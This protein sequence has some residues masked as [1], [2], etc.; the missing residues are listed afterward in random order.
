MTH[1]DA[2]AE[3]AV[4]PRAHVD[5]PDGGESGIGGLRE[6]AAAQ[7]P[8]EERLHSQTARDHEDVVAPAEPH[9]RLVG[10][11]VPARLGQR[12]DAQGQV[13]DHLARVDDPQ[14]G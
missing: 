1:G 9:P 12:L 3:V 5:R 7:G 11:D 2:V 4:D 14:T 8:G 13:D 6:R 10:E